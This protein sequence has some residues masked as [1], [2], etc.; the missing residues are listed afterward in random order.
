MKQYL[1]FNDIPTLSLFRFGWPWPPDSRAT[2][3][4]MKVHSYYTGQPV[5]YVCLTNGQMQSLSDT[6]APVTIVTEADVKNITAQLSK[7]LTPRPSRSRKPI[8]VQGAN[9]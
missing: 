2:G 5:H 1:T 6:S 4:C 3:I 9:S 7:R 8:S